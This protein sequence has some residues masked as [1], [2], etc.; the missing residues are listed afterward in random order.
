MLIRP[1]VDGECEEYENMNTSK[2][3]KE[4]FVYSS[5]AF[6]HMQMKVKQL[7]EI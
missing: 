4:S 1:N 3:K 6:R 7:N 5:T 2:R